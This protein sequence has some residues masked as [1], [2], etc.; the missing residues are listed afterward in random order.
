MMTLGVGFLIG[1]ICH[2]MPYQIKPQVFGEVIFCFYSHRER[3]VVRAQTHM[4]L[5]PS[6]C[7][8]PG[9]RLHASHAFTIYTRSYLQCFGPLITHFHICS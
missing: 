2:A 9:F 6:I 8:L 3:K 5:Q 7:F 4:R 1:R